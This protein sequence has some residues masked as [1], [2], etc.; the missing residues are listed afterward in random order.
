[1]FLYN[2]CKLF[3]GIWSHKWGDLHYRLYV[4]VNRRRS[5]IMLL[6][7]IALAEICIHIDRPNEV[8]RTWSGLPGEVFGPRLNEEEYT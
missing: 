1:M 2:I 5:E 8:R 6:F 7:N 4:N 3:N